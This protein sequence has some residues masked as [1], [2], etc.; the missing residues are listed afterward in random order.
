MSYP[1]DA[2]CTGPYDR[3]QRV[4]KLQREERALRKTIRTATHTSQTIL[5]PHGVKLL[6]DQLYRVVQTIAHLK[7]LK[8]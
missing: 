1:S 6:E 8:F 7:S 3:L 2:P 4:K 5:S